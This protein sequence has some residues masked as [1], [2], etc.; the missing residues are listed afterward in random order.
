MKTHE[1]IKEKLLQW[2]NCDI[3]RCLQ[4]FDAVGWAAGRASGL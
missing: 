3:C 2:I 1:P 4:Y